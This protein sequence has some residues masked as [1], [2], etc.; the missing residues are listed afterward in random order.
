MAIVG[1]AG[2]LSAKGAAQLGVYMV[3]LSLKLLFHFLF[4]F[5]EG[6]AA[7]FF[8][9]ENFDFRDDVGYFFFENCFADHMV[10]LIFM[11]ISF[12]G[13]SRQF[14]TDSGNSD[15]FSR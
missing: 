7:V 6:Y 9:R 14:T 11:G 15:F 5:G 4:Y 2:R 13:Y 8:I 10:P 3:E 12:E 1:I